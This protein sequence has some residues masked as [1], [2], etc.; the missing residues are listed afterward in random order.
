MAI[1][2]LRHQGPEVGRRH[3]HAARTLDRFGDEGR[4]GV[5][6]LENDFTLQLVGHDAAKRGLVLRAVAAD[7]GVAVQPR[8]VDVEA[9]RQQR[10]AG[11]AKA[12]VAVDAHAAKVHAVVAHVSWR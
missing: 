4:H 5:R 8:A 7:I 10:L 2:D 9:A 1:A 12:R 11:T 3:D 6:A